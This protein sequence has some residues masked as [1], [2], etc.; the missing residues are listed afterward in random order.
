MRAGSHF[1]FAHAQWREALHR[2][3]RSEAPDPHGAFRMEFVNPTDGSS[4]MPTISAF[5]Q[6]VPKRGATRPSRSTDGSVHVVTEGKGAVTIAE[7]SFDLAPGDIFVVPSWSAR[8]FTA[9]SDLVMF[10]F[11]DRAAQES[12]GLWRESRG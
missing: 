12:L 8:T 2:M 1:V 11:S 9:A 4:V 10:S 7:H 5:C 3:S 6:L